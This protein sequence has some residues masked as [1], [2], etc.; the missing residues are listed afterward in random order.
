M[1][2]D[3]NSPSGSYTP[4]P[5][6]SILIAWG[7]STGYTEEVANGLY[8]RLEPDVDAIVD[9][10]DTPVETLEDFDVLILGIPTWHVG[11]LQD[12]WEDCFDQLLKLDLSGKLVALFGCGDADGYP[13]N[14]QDAMGL[15]WRQVEGRGA[16]LVGKWPIEGYDFQQSEALTPDGNHF[17]GLAI[18]EHSQDELTAERLDR[19]AQQL[20]TEVGERFR[21]RERVVA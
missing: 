12:D 10:A 2:H 8:D 14:F 5:R 9:I 4:E 15:L 13:H 6:P 17:V 20:R 11:E 7:S 16:S 1:A 18:D 21:P 19:W 3:A